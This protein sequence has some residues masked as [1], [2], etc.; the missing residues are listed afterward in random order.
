MSTH[1]AHAL[2]ELALLA[3]LA[4]V[5]G[6]WIVL[7]RLSFFTHATGTATFPGLVVAG[8]WGIAPQVGALGA[9]LAFAGGLAGLSRRVGGTDNTGAA[10]GVLLVGLLALGTILASDVYDSGSG[11]DALLAGSLAAVTTRDLLLTG[12]VVVVVLAADTV[13]RRTWT[14]QTFDPDSARALGAGSR[15]AELALPL[16]VAAAT[17]VAVDAVGALLAGVVLVVPAATV[18]LMTD[19]LRALRVGAG[20]LALAEGSAA[21]HLAG[22]LD[23][24]A[25]PALAVLGG[26]VFAGVSLFRSVGVRTS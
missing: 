15:V 19:E 9:A 11:V 8:P 4:G 21:L 16:A 1:D 26:V 20:V 24:G 5:L 2:A 3:A 13:L 10:T 22:R 7:R 6:P 25:G 23:V 14:A 17:V 18:R 12:A